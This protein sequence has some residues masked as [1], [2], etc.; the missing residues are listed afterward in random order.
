LYQLICDYI[1]VRIATSNETIFILVL[2]GEP[3]QRIDTGA[4]STTAGFSAA[5]GYWL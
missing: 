2:R 5:L 3:F 4:S 1:F